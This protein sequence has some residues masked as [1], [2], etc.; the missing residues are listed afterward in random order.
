[1]LPQFSAQD[2]YFVSHIPDKVV[3]PEQSQVDEF[4][5]PYKPHLPLDPTRPTSHGPQI[6]ADQGSA[7]DIQRHIA[8]L[9]APKV[10]EKAIADFNKIFGRNSYNFV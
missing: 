3:F 6:Y 4:L 10:I 2:G 9:Q 1:M 8:M 5:P 7:I